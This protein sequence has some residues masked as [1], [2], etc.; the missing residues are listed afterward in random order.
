MRDLHSNV[1]V[2][3]VINPQS[4]AGNIALTGATID[5]IGGSGGA[6]E[7]LEFVIVSGAIG[8]GAATF[9]ASL[10]HGDTANLSDGVAITDPSSLILGTLAGASFTGASPNSTFRLGYVG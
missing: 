6:F 10:I 5:R 4:Q 1:S 8:T 7:T 3:P 2:R 9:T